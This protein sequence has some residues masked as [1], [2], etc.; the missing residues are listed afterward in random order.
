M[1][2]LIKCASTGSSSAKVIFRR[3]NTISATNIAVKR[4]CKNMVNTD[5]GSRGFGDSERLGISNDKKLK[6]LFRKGAIA[7][8]EPEEGQFLSTL[9]L[10]SKWWK[11]N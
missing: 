3:G 4:F 2:F 6:E 7:L 5:K 10:S 11:K 1:Q 9:I 8:V